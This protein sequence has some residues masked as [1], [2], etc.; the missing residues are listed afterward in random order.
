MLKE[1][2]AEVKGG[3]LIPSL[4]DHSCIVSHSLF[5]RS[6]VN[7]FYE[8]L[9]CHHGPGEIDIDMECF[10]AIIM[11]IFA[12]VKPTIYIRLLFCEPV[13]LKMRLG[14]ICIHF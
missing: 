7:D 1:K 4:S 14:R 3:A 9:E 5:V 10:R 6:W 8:G 11:G 13:V 2:W 12:E